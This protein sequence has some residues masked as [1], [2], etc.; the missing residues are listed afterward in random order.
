MTTLNEALRKIEATEA[1]FAKLKKIWKELSDLLPLG[2][3]LQYKQ[4]QAQRYDMLS[5]Y[6][7]RI[8][9]VMP[10]IDGFEIRNSI[11]PFH[12]VFQNALN[13]HQYGEIEDSITFEK[14]AREQGTHLSEYYFRLIQKRQELARLVIFDIAQSIEEDIKILKSVE[15]SVRDKINHPAW[16]AMM[17]KMRSI[18]TIIGNAAKKPTG[19]N[20]MMR[21][22]SY[23]EVSDLQNIESFDW[24]SIKAGL[25][26]ALRREYDPIPVEVTDLNILVSRKPTGN[27][28][29]ELKWNKLT[30][31]DFERLIYNTIAT[32]DGYENP[33]W[34]THTNAPDRGRDLSVYRVYKDPLSGVQR[35]RIIIA[36]KHYTSKSV[37]VDDIGILRTQVELWEPPKVDTL[38]IATSSRFTT[39]AIQLIENQNQ[40]QGLRIEMWPCTALEHILSERPDLIG[41]FNLR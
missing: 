8:R 40:K 32:T 11:I 26:E 7:E 38:V 34:L 23:R 15:P 30:P 2:S 37:S 20:E 31:S 35:Q 16:D 18:E 9:T 5:R 36:C 19:W 17:E 12:D 21:H 27:V 14:E 3:V 10:K 33:Q 28:I 29:V 25:E 4:E 24:P 6:F 13:I 39:D 41:E 1:N 22:M